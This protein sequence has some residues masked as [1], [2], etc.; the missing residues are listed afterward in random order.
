MKV[1]IL[2][3]PNTETETRVREYVREFEHRASKAL[4]LVDAE[5]RE[6]IAMAEVYDILQFPTMLAIENDG[7]FIQMWPEFE[8][9]PTMNELTFY[10]RD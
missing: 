3:K 7:Q 1:V 10:A 4:E 6:G 9:W 5:T 8:R 2:Y